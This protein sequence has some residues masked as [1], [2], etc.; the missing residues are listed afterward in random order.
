[1][2]RKG[3]KGRR[4]LLLLQ[5]EKTLVAEPSSNTAPRFWHFLPILAFV[6]LC[7][8]FSRFHQYHHGDSV[9]P[10][11]GSLYQWTPFY[12]ENDRNG[13]LLPLLALPIKSP[14]ANLLFQSGL[15]IFGGLAVYYVLSRYLVKQASWALV[16][17]LA[18]GQYLWLV[19]PRESFEFLCGCQPYSV[20]IA[21][22]IG[23]L[24]LVDHT[25][26]QKGH[27]RILAACFLMAV[28][29]WVN[30]GLIVALGPLIV[31]RGFL[32]KN[33]GAYFAN[34]KMWRE[35]LVLGFGA[36]VGYL[37]METNGSSKEYSR[38]MG[39]ADWPFGWGRL[40]FELW[41]KNTP[42]FW[43][44]SLGF[45]IAG[46]V[47]LAPKR[48]RTA[49][50]EAWRTSFALIGA[51]AVCFLLMGTLHFVRH[52]LFHYRYAFPT[53]LFVQIAA[54]LPSVAAL[55]TMCE[56][57]LPRIAFVLTLPILLAAAIVAFG[58]P[59]LS[60]PR[61]ALDR[62]IGKRTNDIIESR[63]THV[64]GDYFDVWPAVFHANLVL[65]EH[66]DKRIVWGVTHRCGP[67]LSHWSAM[68]RSEM[69]LAVP[70]NARHLDHIDLN[71]VPYVRMYFPDFTVFRRRETVW[72]L[73]LS[74]R[75]TQP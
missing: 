8:D 30:A 28:A 58:V 46:V 19:P 9:V 50:A 29:F 16:A 20:S 54:L 35:L 57:R 1:M 51:A 23:G 53:L 65:H 7:I 39:T 37:L 25:P 45:A 24:L 22:G 14:Y 40:A 64:V 47:A 74:E 75:T 26:G 62:S 3:F 67:T 61:A 49:A 10:I 71:E 70:V 56:R 43:L 21:L 38:Q 73:A 15:A 69:R 17:T 11:L 36:A 6:A 63:S 12:W 34:R 27:W 2:N 44:T 48:T 66:G 4:G 60:E 5:R 32:H 42:A 41:D 52:N 55:E 13:W 31:L 59:S 18:A 68:P 72:L 33:E